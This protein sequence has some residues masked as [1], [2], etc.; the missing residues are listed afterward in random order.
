MQLN[1]NL[2]MCLPTKDRLFLESEAS[3]LQKGLETT[4]IIFLARGVRH[5]KS[6]KAI[7]W[8]SDK[9]QGD[10]KGDADSVWLDVEP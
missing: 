4:L 7:N 3:R 9:L 6:E 8:E 1:K 5:L 2:R 10:Q